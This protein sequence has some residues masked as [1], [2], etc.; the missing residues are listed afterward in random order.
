MLTSPDVE[1]V[2][3]NIES[4]TDYLKE[5]PKLDDVK[6]RIVSLN[7]GER[8]ISA[9][10]LKSLVTNP[11]LLA[12]LVSDEKIAIMVLPELVPRIDDK[13]LFQMELARNLRSQNYAFNISWKSAPRL[14]L[15]DLA[16][17]VENV[18]S[19]LIDEILARSKNSIIESMPKDVAGAFLGANPKCIALSVYKKRSHFVIWDIAWNIRKDEKIAYA[20]EFQ[21]LLLHREIPI[22]GGEDFE[23]FLL[24][25]TDA[26]IQRTVD[27][28]QDFKKIADKL[29]LVENN[30]KRLGFKLDRVMEGVSYVPY[31]LKDLINLGV[32]LLP[33]GQIKEYP[34][35]S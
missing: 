35:K 1:A 19:S 26:E 10:E 18:D 20:H 4:L 21:S 12:K 9:E 28:N 14:L 15:H 22:I 17:P 30:I 32:F 25:G 3:Y 8:E 24:L 23:G 6:E 16:I 13:K 33:N 29:N 34:L 27:K 7:P 2:A 31:P 5:D 11:A